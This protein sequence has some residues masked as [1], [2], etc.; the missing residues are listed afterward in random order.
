MTSAPGKFRTVDALAA[1]RAEWKRLLSADQYHVLREHGTEPPF[2]NAYWARH[3]RGTFVCAGCGLEL[4]ESDKKFDSGTG[5]PSFWTHIA[6]HVEQ[7]P[8]AD[9][10]RTE[11]S[12]AR[13]GGHLGHVFDDGPEPTHLR[14]CINSAALTF[15]PAGK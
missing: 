2:H 9:G 11:L 1:M 4:F 5:W 8:D 7:S 15:V 6:N 12:C 10:N 3:D 13:C 14:Y